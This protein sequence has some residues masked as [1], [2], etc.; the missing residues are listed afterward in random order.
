VGY[1]RKEKVIFSM[2]PIKLYALVTLLAFKHF[3][4][5]L[6]RAGF[7]STLAR[8]DCKLGKYLLFDLLWAWLTLLPT[9]GPFPQTSHL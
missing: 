6:I 1:E 2:T 7:P 8:T 4:Q 9:I 5:T 3:A